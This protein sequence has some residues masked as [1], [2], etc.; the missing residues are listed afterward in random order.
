MPNAI[1]KSFSKKSGKSIKELE[2]MWDA[3]DSAFDPKKHDDK[4]AFIVGVMKKNLKLDENSSFDRMLI[5][6]FKNF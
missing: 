5:E 3:L 1:L 6:M 4:Y 2:K